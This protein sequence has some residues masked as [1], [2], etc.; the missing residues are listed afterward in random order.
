VDA[1]AQQNP[2]A[3]ALMGEADNGKQKGRRGKPAASF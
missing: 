2:A 1:I 3:T